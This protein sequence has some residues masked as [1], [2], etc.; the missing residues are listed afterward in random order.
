ML[1]FGFA[2]IVDALSWAVVVSL[3]IKVIATIILLSRDRASR[4]D[5]PWGPAL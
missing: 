5:G 1:T 4:F 3:G 2:T